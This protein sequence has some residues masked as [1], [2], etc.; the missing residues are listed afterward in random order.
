M[1]LAFK[2]NVFLLVALLLFSIYTKAQPAN[3]N[4]SGAIILTSNPTITPTS[5]TINSATASLASSGTSCVNWSTNYDVWYKF[6]PT[7]TQSYTITVDG[8]GSNFWSRE[9]Q[10]YDGGTGGGT[11]PTVGTGQLV[12]GTSGSVT[13]SGTANRTY[14]IRISDSWTYMNWGGDFNVTVSHRLVA[15]TNNSCTNAY[16]LNQ[17]AACN[18]TVAN[19]QNAVNTAPTGAC[20]G[21]TSTTTFG[22]WFKFT[23]TSTS[24]VISLSGLGAKF[25]TVNPYVELLSATSGCGSTYT[26]LACQNAFTNPILNYT[27]LTV[28]ST[29]YI[30]LYATT[31][32]NATPTA[33]WN[34]TICVTNPI[35]TGGRTN[36]IFRQ[37]LLVSPNTPLASDRLSDPWEITYGP[38]DS[39]WVTEAKGYKVKKISPVNGGQRTILDLSDAA[40]GGTFTPSSFRRQFARSQ[41]PWPQGGMMGLAL[42]P[43][44]NHPTT[45]K[46]YVYVAYVRSYVTPFKDVTDTVLT[47]PTPGDT[48]KGYLFYT[49]LVRFDYNG[50]NLVNPQIICDTI[51]GSSDHNSGRMIIK[52][53][54]GTNYLVYAVGDMGAGQ[55]ANYKRTIKA[56]DSSSYEGKILRFNTE[57]DAD[58]GA[59]D[60]WIPNNNPF[61]TVLGKQSAV[62]SV[63]LRNNQGFAYNSNLD[64]IY[65]SSHG[66]FSDDE[67]NIIEGNRNYGH[68][69][70]I[71]DSTDGNYNN[72]KAGP[73]N[74]TLPLITSESTNAKNINTRMLATGTTYKNPI[75]NFYS[76]VAGSTATPW[77]IQYIYTNQPYPGTP[78]TG[79]QNTNQFWA[80]EAPSG[81]D[82]YTSGAIP[83]WRNS[84]LTATL[85]GGRIIRNQ[86]NAA[87]TSVIPVNGADT[88][89]YFRG[90]NRFRDIAISPDG[91]DIFAVIDSSSTTSGPTTSNPIVSACRGCLQ[92]Y[93]FLG[94]ADNAGASTISTNIPIAPGI[95]NS[96]STNTPTSITTADN[97]NI[98]VPITD[99]LGNIIAEIDANGNNLGNITGSFYK[100]TGA[101]RTSVSGRPYL[102]RSMTINVE[103]TPATNVNIRLYLTAAELAALAAAPSSGVSDINGVFV[104]K[105]SDASSATMIQTPTKITPT[106]ASFGSN[107]VLTA[108]ISGFSS[109]YIGGPGFI[110][111]ADQLVLN[112]KY[113][114]QTVLLDWKTTNESNASHFILE[115]SFDGTTFVNINNTNAIGNTTGNTNYSYNDKDAALS[116]AKI[117]YYRIKLV[118]NDG[119]IIQS[120]TITVSLPSSIST[121]TVVP[122]PATYEIK[123]LVNASGDCNATWSIFDN[124][125][126]MVATN[127]TFIKKG[128]NQLNINI[129]NLAKGMYYI[130]VSGA[131]IDSRSKFHKM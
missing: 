79:A 122:N 1:L 44:F 88:V 78:N 40:S 113:N 23:A 119:R 2:K 91:K 100:K 50:T 35:V 51:K 30:R 8:H 118:N 84:L 112:G 115:R 102:D 24:A 62:W 63:G 109:F 22:T 82:L 75:F 58:A 21:A 74:G 68:P 46:K 13:I 76:P 64:I 77:S 94:Y 86:L 89:T 80:S 123:A 41:N 59:Y 34:Y 36:E 128:S 19:L 93:T 4:C 65:G 43:D 71:G 10:V 20:G 127:S 6:T 107:Y 49:S 38:D 131:T 27:G 121:L 83:G 54:A 129:S 69:L 111:A 96:L 101:I 33:D 60:K 87:G 106:R 32:P 31:N 70:V 105:N 130:H 48:V 5:G 18:S 117:V 81:I 42:H 39:L 114:N 125:G 45:P 7:V 110:L 92:R 15:S 28:G 14:F 53:I 126:K 61:N 9:F 104:Y 29:Y 97:N 11:C 3:D 120:N 73:S 98:W 17:G 103:N 12:C 66:P 108:S 124:T 52:P 26:S 25:S 37:T 67:M 85:K 116:T 57:P 72:A 95:S 16:T 56:Q 99:S 55:F 47:S 90:V